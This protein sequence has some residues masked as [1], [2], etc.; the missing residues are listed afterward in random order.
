MAREWTALKFELLKTRRNYR[1]CGWWGVNPFI[2]YMFI[3]FVRFIGLHWLT[4]SWKYKSH[5]IVAS[6]CNLLQT[7]LLSYT[8]CLCIHCNDSHN[9]MHYCQL[10]LFGWIGF[11][12]RLLDSLNVDNYRHLKEHSLIDRL[13]ACWSTVYLKNAKTLFLI[14]V[15]LGN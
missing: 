5:K 8:D 10:L 3:A 14:I 1:G 15:V 12:A 4:D 6:G 2:S 13:S 11:W 9:G 7:F